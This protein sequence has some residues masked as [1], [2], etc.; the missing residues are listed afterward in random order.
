MSAD[1][2]IDFGRR[3]DILR[4]I[5]HTPARKL[6][7]GKPERH[8]SGV[9]VQPIPYDPMLDASSLH[10]KIADERGYF[11]IDFLNVSVYQHIKDE[12]HYQALLAK[13]PPWERLSDPKFVEQIIHIA[14]YPSQLQFTMPD[15]IPR[16]AMFLSILRPGKKHLQGKSWKEIRETVWLKDDGDQ[17][18]FRHSHAIAYATLVGLHM[19][20]VDELE[21]STCPPS[22]GQE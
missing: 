6:H 18:S 8:N 13:E 10:Y 14:N 20:I 1:I 17:Y 21:K 7:Q 4:H 19:N 3:D 2:D 16:M 15:S 9:Y 11:K 22:D 5:K 12:A